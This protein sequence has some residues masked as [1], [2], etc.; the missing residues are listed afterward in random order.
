[1]DRDPLIRANWC[2]FSIGCI[3]R[4]DE[5]DRTRA[6]EAI[7]APLRR[8]IR[9]AGPLQW[10][11]AQVLVELTES[12][13]A[14]LGSDGA[15]AYWRRNLRDS[16]DHPF[17][18][19]LVTGGLFL[20]GRSPIGLAKRAPQGWQLVTKNCGELVVDVDEENG[21]IVASFEDLPPVFHGTVGLRDLLVGGFE[22]AFDVAGVQGRVLPD[23]A[24]AFRVTLVWP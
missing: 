7:G 4:L 22:A 5:P 18:K 17:L 16:M 21:R 1:M 23:A 9:E 6:L 10:L 2:K 24:D 14:G 20:F 3:K 13:H 12:L 8:E 11:P 15:V 19:P